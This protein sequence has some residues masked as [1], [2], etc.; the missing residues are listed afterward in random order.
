MTELD[1]KAGGSTREVFIS[2]SRRDKDNP[3]LLELEKRL[4]AA[5]IEVFKDTESIR[6]GTK[7]REQIG[8]GIQRCDMFLLVASKHSFQSDAVGDELTAAEHYKKP[9]LVIYLDPVE[10]PPA[11]VVML[12]KWQAYRLHGDD[13]EEVEEAY[14]DILESLQPAQPVASRPAPAEAPG[15]P[16]RKLPLVYL[17]PAVVIVA[18]TA[19]FGRGMLAT[20][21]ASF[22]KPEKSIV[23]VMIPPPYHSRSAVLVIEE[24][25]L[26]ESVIRTYMK[27]EGKKTVKLEPLVMEEEGSGSTLTKDGAELRLS[28]DAHYRIVLYGIDPQD[29]A[30]RCNRDNW[31]AR[32]AHWEIDPATSGDFLE[33]RESGIGLVDDINY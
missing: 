31:G 29:M 17:I 16:R 32:Y 24:E 25:Y 12:S 15:A 21:L 10:I 22:E 7:W 27:A 26:D 11:L 28:P 23:E 19:A 4:E 30:D 14:Q 2:Y 3:R 33:A 18:L 9:C 13:D 20:V 1:S 5:G 8:L 6:G